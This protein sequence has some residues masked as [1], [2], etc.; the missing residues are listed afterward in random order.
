M[1]KKKSCVD[2]DC[3]V[4]TPN[5]MIFSSTPDNIGYLQCGGRMADMCIYG[6]NVLAVTQ[7]GGNVLTVTHYDG[8]FSAA[9]GN[10]KYDG[11]CRNGTRYDGNF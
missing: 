6:G 8:N 5:H 4:R 3:E 9:N 2:T 10:A 1:S 7:Y 11:H